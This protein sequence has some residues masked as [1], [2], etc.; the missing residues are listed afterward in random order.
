MAYVLRVVTRRPI[1][2]IAAGQLDPRNT[3]HPHD[4]VQPYL[5]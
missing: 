2:V 3:L 5:N 4:S 1:M